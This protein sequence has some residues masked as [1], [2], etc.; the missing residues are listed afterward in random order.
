LD[1]PRYEA[2]FYEWQALCHVATLLK[3]PVLTNVRQFRPDTGRLQSPEVDGVAED[4]RRR[5][6]IETKSYCLAQE[7]TDSIIA[8]YSK[9]RP[10]ELLLVAPSYKSDLALPRYARAI[11]F[12]PDLSVLKQAYWGTSVQIA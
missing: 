1:S 7:D 5:I 6:L 11:S 2:K 9:F 8:K 3:I 12:L 10:D 4:R